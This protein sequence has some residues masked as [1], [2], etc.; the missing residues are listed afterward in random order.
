MSDVLILADGVSK[1]FCRR[2]RKS[3]WYGVC[4]SVA[5]MTGVGPSTRLRREEFWAVNDLSFEVRRGE[6][7]GLIGSN[8]AGKTTLLK[9]LNGLIKP[10]KGRIEMRGRVGALIALSAGFNPILTGR[11]NVYVYGSILGLTKKEIDGI[12]DEIVDFAEIEE[13]IDTPVQSY[14][15]GMQVRLGFAVASALQPDILLVDEVLAVGDVRF[16]W[17]CFERIKRL[18]ENGVCIILVSHNSRDLMRTCTE[19]LVLSAGKLMFAGG[20]E[21]AVLGY[22]KEPAPKALIAPR[23]NGAT[24]PIHVSATT[25]R[26]DGVPATT[27]RSGDALD[28]VIEVEAMQKIERARIVLAL[29]HSEFGPLFAVSSF[30]CCGWIPISEGTNVVTV[31][32]GR[33]PIQFGS[34]YVEASVLGP[35]I[36]D[37]YD[38]AKGHV[39]LKVTEPAPNYEGF[40]VNGILLPSADWRLQ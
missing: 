24:S 35:E 22:E 2:F 12:F 13:F 34:Y 28:V 3:L 16:R 40:G 39:A 19:G 32:L 17:K 7:L 15:S 25:Y 36:G 30:A 37:I 18:K 31:S 5:D 29:L 10:D 26:V 20:I 9:M 1:K 38:I 4:D 11:E 27:M 14:S 8:G 23:H 21:E 6:C 33:L